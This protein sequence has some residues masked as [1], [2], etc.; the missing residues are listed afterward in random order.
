[1]P[2][3]P[4]PSSAVAAAV[5]GRLHG[6]VVIDAWRPAVQGAVGHVLG[7]RDG[8]GDP[9]VVKIFPA[10]A[11]ARAATEVLALRMLDG[12]TDV[13]APRLVLDGELPDGWGS[14]IVMTRLTGV[15]WADRRTDLDVDQQAVLHRDVA[16]LLRGLH[17]LGGEWFGGLVAEGPRWPTA[18][19]R[20]TRG[21]TSP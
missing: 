10:G 5:Q 11:D 6:P 15:R 13:P 3:T 21:A 4:V 1:M 20:K 8:R 18:W 2:V 16:A 19:D 17:R 9:Y 7:L 12:V 14:Y